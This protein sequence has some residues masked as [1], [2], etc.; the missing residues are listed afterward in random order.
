M[1]DL[2]VV[3]F[4]QIIVVVLLYCGIND[5]GICM[6]LVNLIKMGMEQV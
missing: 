2:V 1:D 5:E 3:M 4:N 6:V